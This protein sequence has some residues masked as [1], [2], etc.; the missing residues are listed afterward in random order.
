MLTIR[1]VIFGVAAGLL[2][3]VG[4][5]FCQTPQQ[6][7]QAPRTLREALN[8][9][10]NEPITVAGNLPADPSKRAASTQDQLFA[11]LTAARIQAKSR[12]KLGG[13]NSSGFGGYGY[14]GLGMSGARNHTTEINPAVYSD[15][16]PTGTLSS[17][18]QEQLYLRLRQEGKNVL[19]PSTG[20]MSDQLELALQEAGYAQPAGYKPP[21]IPARY[22]VLSSYSIFDEKVDKN[23][24]NGAPLGCIL[25]SSG[26]RVGNDVA[27]DIMVIGGGVLSTIDRT[28]ERRT[29]TLVVRFHLVD[30]NTRQAVY[31]TEAST[32]VENA[33][34][35]VSNIAGVEH[36]T[37]S[38]T[39]AEYLAKLGVQS[40]FTAE[41]S[42]PRPLQ[43]QGEDVP[44]LARRADR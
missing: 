31:S 43:S 38:Q 12:Y 15:R 40:L 39:N 7:N 21:H 16:N 27:R 6:A 19:L 8:V 9:V 30:L 22:A 28:R 5:V 4:Y 10:G 26:W 41:G 14:C 35:S 42:Y 32:L 25:A 44:R 23:G 24:F 18:I 11:N 36:L 17:L 33:E 3:S 2:I 1:R 34:L 37:L 13:G 29:V 20:A